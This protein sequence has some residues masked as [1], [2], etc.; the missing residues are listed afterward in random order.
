M[1]ISHGLEFGA[2]WLLTKFVQII[3]GSLADRI[4]VGLGRLAHRLLKSRREIARDNIVRSSLGI[5]GS[6]RIDRIVRE[7]FINIART[8]V[9]FCRQPVYSREDILGMYEECPDRHYIDEVRESGKG[10]MLISPHFGNW[11]LLAGLV[12]AW[13]YPLDLLVGEQHNN[14]VND[15]FISFR[16]SQGVGIIPIGVAARRVIKS[17][18]AG[19]FVAVVSDQHA[20]SGGIVV[21]FLGRKASTPAGPAA[22]AVKT[23][24]PILCGCSVRLGYNRHRI[25]VAP[26]IYPPNSGDTSRD[27]QTMTGEYTGRFEK[28]IREY[29][30]Q[31]M[32]THRRWKID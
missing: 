30:E 3:P 17:L 27:I 25:I 28:M 24:S 19:R 6:D 21:N 16:E 7:V 2:I 31:W 22:F 8:T 11:E 15:L 26:P 20:A 18:R 9:E 12:N 13:G 5:E 23:D 1:K 29:P 4:A 14:K 32:W 10:A